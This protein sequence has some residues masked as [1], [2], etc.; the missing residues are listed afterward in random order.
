MPR[1]IILDN[2]TGS[3][4][5]DTLDLDGPPREEGPL[6]AV[7]RFDALT[8]EDKRSYAL[9]HPS[10]ALNESVG[11]IVYLAPDDYPKIK[12]GRDQDV[13]DAMIADCE[14][15]AFVEVREL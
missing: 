3:I 7:E 5:A 14:P 1:Y 15:V 13:I 8:L 2:V 11:Y 4:V 10:A 12:D 6:E 9:E